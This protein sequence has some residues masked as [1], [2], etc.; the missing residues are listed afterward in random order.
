MYLLGKTHVALCFI[1]IHY[2]VET[3]CIASLP[4][5]ASLRKPESFIKHIYVHETLFYAVLRFLG[6]C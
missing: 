2:S 6:F 5:I 1:S 4:C 3:Q